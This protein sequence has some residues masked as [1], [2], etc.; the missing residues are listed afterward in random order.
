MSIDTK[1]KNNVHP[2]K[3]KEF[4]TE[5]LKILQEIKWI[6]TNLLQSPSKR[7]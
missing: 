4:E 5:V 1:E 3:E 7:R 6:V 2:E